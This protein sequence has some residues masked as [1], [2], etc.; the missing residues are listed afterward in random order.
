M[1]KLLLCT[2]LFL[3]Y[4][5]SSQTYVSKDS[6]LIISIEKKFMKIHTTNELKSSYVAITHWNVSTGVAFGGK[7]MTGL[8]ASKTSESRYVVSWRI[9]DKTG[10]VYFTPVTDKDAFCQIRGEF[11]E[12]NRKFIKTLRNHQPCVVNFEFPYPEGLKEHKVFLSLSGDED[13]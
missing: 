8:S 3:C 7:P 10:Y 13:W 2:T 12:E 1:K 9:K 5:L 11:E 6:L 4:T